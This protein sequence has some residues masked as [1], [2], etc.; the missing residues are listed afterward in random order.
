[1]IQDD[2][3]GYDVPQLDPCI[4]L[5]APVYL[6]LVDSML[7][8]SMYRLN[9]NEWTADQRESFRY[10]LFPSFKQSIQTLVLK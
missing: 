7:K 6:T 1:M 2:I 5:Y 10:L 4:Q 3:I 8:K 9:E